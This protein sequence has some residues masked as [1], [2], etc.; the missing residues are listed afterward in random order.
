MDAAALLATLEASAPAVAIRNSLVL[1]PLIESFHV[2]GLTLVFGTIAILDLRLLGLASTR[3]SFTAVASDVLPW[4]WAAFALTVATGVLMFVTNATTYYPNPYFQAKVLLLALSGV[5]MT[6][7]ELTAR[8]TVREWDRDPSAPP[9]GRIV[10]VV[11]LVVWISVIVLGRWVG[12]TSARATAPTD[13]GVDFDAIEEL[14]P[15]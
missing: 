11:S 3:R 13:P 1:F 6:V 9:A 7:F 4:T 5:N 12:F 2:L 14:L 15:K 10:A 8:R